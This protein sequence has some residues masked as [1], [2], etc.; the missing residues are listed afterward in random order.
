MNRPGYSRVLLVLELDHP[1]GHLACCAGLQRL[2]VKEIV[3]G[4]PAEKVLQRAK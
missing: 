4:L 3:H 2:G 1:T